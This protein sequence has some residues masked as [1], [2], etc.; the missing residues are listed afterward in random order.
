MS[1]ETEM[2]EYIAS[3][4]RHSKK[5]YDKE[6]YKKNRGKKIEVAIKWQ[7]DHKEYSKEYK[8]NWLAN[9]NEKVLE[10]ARKY[11]DNNREKILEQSR[12][13][14]HNNPDK[15]LERVKEYNKTEKGKVSKQRVKFR[16]RD[17]RFVSLNNYFDG[18]EAH[19]LDDTYVVYIPKK[20]HESI[21]H[22][23]ETGKGM[24]EINSYAM[25][26]ANIGGI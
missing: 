26:Y 15:F 1:N 2:L 12:K 14:Y 11:R 22:C 20:V 16:R 5:E 3:M 7:E 13:C 25:L 8:K 6:Y 4:N 18:S 21:Y 24:E 9:N 17:L 23:L 10:Y 19:H